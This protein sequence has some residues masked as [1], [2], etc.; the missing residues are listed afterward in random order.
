VLEEIILPVE[1][2]LLGRP[3]LP[4]ADQQPERLAR[5]RKREQR[6]QMI[7]HEQK[8]IRPPQIFFLPAI[9][10]DKIRFLARFHPQRNLVRQALATT[11]G[12]G[13][14]KY[15]IL[16]FSINHEAHLDEVEF[17]TVSGEVVELVALRQVAPRSAALRLPRN[18]AT[19]S[20]ASRPL[21]AGGVVAVRRLPPRTPQKNI[22]KSLA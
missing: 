14:E 13:P 22:S 17:T 7:G 3:F 15:R 16:L 10:G 9:D 19:S 12:Y 21:D 18:L 4:F 6:M 20:V 2:Q 8:E 5:R 1:A 11:R